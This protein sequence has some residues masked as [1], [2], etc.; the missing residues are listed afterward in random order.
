M[1]ADGI[2]MMFFLGSSSKSRRRSDMH[3]YCIHMGIAS[4][5]LSVWLFCYGLPPPPME[6]RRGL[7]PYSCSSLSLLRFV[8]EE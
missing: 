3:G 5:L 1:L 4:V 6:I 7:Y 8:A 2:M